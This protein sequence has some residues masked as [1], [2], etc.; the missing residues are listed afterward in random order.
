[1]RMANVSPADCE[2]L[3]EKLPTATIHC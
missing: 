1:L 2:A 3:K